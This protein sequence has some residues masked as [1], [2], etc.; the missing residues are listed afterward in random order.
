MT[1]ILAAAAIAAVMLV[2][3]ARIPP[4]PPPPPPSAAAPLADLAGRSADAALRE[5]ER[6]LARLSPER[7]KDPVTI[8]AAGTELDL[9]IAGERQPE[10][11]RYRVNG[12]V[13]ERTVT[14]DDPDPE[15]RPVPDA[16]L[17]SVRFR[18]LTP[19]PRPELPWQARSPDS[20]T[21]LEVLLEATGP[22][23]RGSE[24]RVQV[25]PVRPFDSKGPETPKG[26]RG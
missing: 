20:S 5:L 14:G 22:D 15:T 24:R 17:R 26:E 23:G 1:E 12:R 11:V 21:Y 9:R 16:F 13:L 6:D 10:R 3:R 8:G 19:R 7:G 4:R 2:V 18:L 25:S